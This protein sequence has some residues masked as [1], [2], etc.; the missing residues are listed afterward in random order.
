[1]LKKIE[2]GSIVYKL[3]LILIY[4]FLLS[5]VIVIFLASIN[6]TSYLTF[7]PKQVTLAWYKK[8]LTESQ[9]IAGFQYSLWVAG[10][11]V[12]ISTAIG[13]LAAYAIVRYRFSGRDVLN[14]F[15]LSPLIFPMIIIGIALLQFYNTLKISGTFWGLACAHV[16]ITFPYVIRTVSA[17][18]YR[19]DTTL[20]EAALTLGANGIKTFFLVTLPLIKPGVIAGAIFAFIVSFD[21]VPV[22]IFLV[23]VKSTTLP[24]VIFSYI[25][26]GV[27]PTI[28]AISTLLVCFT[29]IA[30]LC[31]ERWIGFGKF[32]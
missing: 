8:A 32:V 26:Y 18:L 5:P 19:L 9:Y 10:V 21:N 17:S 3:F 25:E 29:G 4:L 12:C 6:P 31:I 2:L 22:S 28:A 14:A 27:D 24:V 11:T 23:G 7:P 15:V 1:M 30:I 13:T 16:V 20:E